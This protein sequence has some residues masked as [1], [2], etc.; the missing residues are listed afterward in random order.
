MS[1]L[2]PIWLVLTAAIVVP[3][4]LHLMRR[5]IDTRIEFPAVRY[6]A[7]AE[8]ENIRSLKL[9]NLL[10]MLLRT[11]AVLLLA[12]AAARPIGWLIGAGHVP[13]ALAVVLDNSL[14]SSAIVDG[15]PLLNR[16]KDGARSVVTGATSSDRVWLVT[17]D[18][19]VTGGTTAAVRDAVDRTR[20]FGGRGDLAAAAARAAGLVLAA[21]LPEREVMIVSDGQATQWKDNVSVGEARVVA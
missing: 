3:L 1:F 20:V 21:G 5:H 18:G 16:L 7:R 14:S 8:K 9:R 4:A 15:T 11:L 6:L 12:L 2:A 13:T 10:L 19:A 17:I